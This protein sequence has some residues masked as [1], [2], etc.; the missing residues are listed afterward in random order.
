MWAIHCQTPTFGGK[1]LEIVNRIVIP[2]WE[3]VCKWQAKALNYLIDENG[4]QVVFSHIHNVDAMVISSGIMG[5]IV[6]L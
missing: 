5:K 3:E 2:T 4:Y 6:R 1:N